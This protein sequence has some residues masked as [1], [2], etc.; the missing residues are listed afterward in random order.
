MNLK[1]PINIGT[2]VGHLTKAQTSSRI[3]RIAS[4]YRCG[5]AC[6]VGGRILGH[7]APFCFFQTVR[8]D[9]GANQE[10]PQGQ[11]G[12]GRKFSAIQAEEENLLERRAEI[13]CSL[14]R[15]SLFR[16]KDSACHE[17]DDVD[18]KGSNH[19]I[20]SIFIESKRGIRSKSTVCPI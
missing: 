18:S 2:E 1:S 6:S 4:I 13:R 9:V 8:R 12:F 17:N 16:N 10:E 5:L 3:R 7:L 19:S 20:C 15:Q 11:L 14:S